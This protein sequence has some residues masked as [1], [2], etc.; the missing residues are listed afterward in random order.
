MAGYSDRDRSSMASAVEWSGA[1]AGN[2]EDGK[3]RTMLDQ[4]IT[5]GK[6]A[7]PCM[8]RGGS[9]KQYRERKSGRDAVAEQCRY[10]VLNIEFA[11]RTAARGNNWTGH[12]WVLSCCID[13]T[14]WSSLPVEPTN[15][16]AFAGRPANRRPANRTITSRK[17]VTE[18]LALLLWF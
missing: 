7:E 5:I 18:A 16:Q 1:T 3:E 2:G 13:V 17:S 9:R 10:R 8:R 12:G 4:H 15:V 11:L 14:G 6:S